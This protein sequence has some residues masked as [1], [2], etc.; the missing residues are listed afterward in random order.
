[1]RAAQGTECV[2]ALPGGGVLLLGR[3]GVCVKLSILI[4]LYN[5]AATIEELLTKVMA[6]ALPQ[7]VE[8]EVV[9][10]DDGSSDGSADIV[11]KLKKA[12]LVFVQHPRNAGKGAALR[13]AI[14]HAT[15]EIG[16]IQDADLEYD[17]AD[18]PQLLAP[19]LNGSADVV[20]GSRFAS[21][22]GRPV[23]FSLHRF[24]NR[25]LTSL[26]NCFSRLSITDM[27][28]C[29]KAFRIEIVRDLN[30]RE[31]GFGIEVELTLKFGRRGVR[32]VEVP[33]S[34][35]GR[36]A[37]EGKKLRPLRDGLGALR[38]ML[39]YGFSLS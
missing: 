24:V 15:G 17:M 31:N 37:S 5:E 39:R 29:Y 4:P 18:Y 1:M 14:R 33:I 7:G 27:E 16:L 32:V 36:S 10:V 2:A 8:R 28:T 38:C 26:S 13:T 12:E 30:L 21:Q 3:S 6:T 34:Y 22:R 25:S 23:H 11:R 19:L 20:Y 9:V 35:K